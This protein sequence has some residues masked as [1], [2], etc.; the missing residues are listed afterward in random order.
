MRVFWNRHID[1]RFHVEYPHARRDT[2]RV[3]GITIGDPE[4]EW[5]M[6]ITWRDR[7]LREAGVT[8][9]SPPRQVARAM[10]ETFRHEHFVRK[11]E[12]RLFPGSERMHTHAI[13]GLIHTSWCVGCS[14]AFVA[15]ADACGL[16]ARGVGMPGHH[17][18]EVC[19]DGDWLLMDPAGRHKAGD[20]VWFDG[21]FHDTMLDPMGDWT[22]TMPDAKRV[23]FWKRPYG[24]YDFNGGQ[25]DIPGEVYFAAQSAHALYP[26][27]TRYGFK[28]PDGKRMPIRVTTCGFI[29]PG[30]NAGHDAPRY[31]ALRAAAVP[32]PAPEA[33]VTA[34]FL[35]H[36]FTPGQK[37]RQSFWLGDRDMEQVEIT[38]AFAPSRRSDWSA[39]AGAQLKV[40]AGDFTDSLAALGAWP[41]RP[42]T[43]AESA[44]LPGANRG[45]WHS[46]VS[47]APD[48]FRKDAVNWVE[49]SH[50]SHGL[51]FIPCIT[52]MLEPYIP[53]LFA[54]TGDAFQP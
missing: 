31:A 12:S 30:V 32:D 2:P 13:E 50:K 16:P 44:A 36:P 1:R 23:G 15:L 38:F 48:L 11:P 3:R 33:A 19:A 37:L 54:E 43:P 41:P 10:S 9:S 46:T 29:W 6:L 35:Y 27:N 5:E 25:W 4:R 22:P 24:I 39:A 7:L 42:M 52:S 47:L 53:P 49:L 26:N 18:A 34:D 14:R 17:V 21:S 28:A 20:P 40:T 8:L 45:L 51:Y